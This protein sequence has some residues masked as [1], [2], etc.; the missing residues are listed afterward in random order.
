VE[1]ERKKLL[2]KKINKEREFIK[3]KSIEDKI[4]VKDASV[5]K[6]QAVKLDAIEIKKIY[7]K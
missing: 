4:I 3:K 6:I 7:E 5:K 1:A 2:F